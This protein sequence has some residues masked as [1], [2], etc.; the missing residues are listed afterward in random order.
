MRATKSYIVHAPKNTR[1]HYCELFTCNSGFIILAW[2][3]Q[4]FLLQIYGGWV[5][6]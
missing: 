2:I 6:L 5:L 4:P 3:V 1:A